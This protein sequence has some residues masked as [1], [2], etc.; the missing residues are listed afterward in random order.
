MHRTTRRKAIAM[1]GAVAGAASLPFPSLAQ[2]RDHVV[3]V[4]GGFGGATCAV[5]LRR[6]APGVDV[7]LIEENAAFATCPFSNAVIAGLNSMD[8]ITHGFDGLKARGVRVIQARAEHVDVE[9]SQVRLTGGEYVDF[10]RLVLSPGVEMKWQAI[11]G[12][13]RSAAEIMP[14]AWK[15]GPQT[16]LLRR[17]LQAMDDGGTVLMGI[18]DSPYRC[19]PGPYERA[20]LIAHYLKTHKPRSKLLL[21]DAKNSFSKQTLF[22]EAWAELYPDLIEWVPFSQIG[23]IRRVDPSD[24]TVHTDF[25]SER[26]DVVNF[27]PPQRAGAIIHAA[28]LSEG[29]DWCRVD[30]RTMESVVAPGV[31][32]LGDAGIMGAMPKSGF[33]AASQAKYCAYVIAAALDEADLPEASFFNTCYSLVAPDYGISVAAVFRIDSAGQIV[34]IEGS[35]GASPEGASADFRQREADYARGWYASQTKEIYDMPS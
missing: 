23:A 25:A 30:P 11:E 12:Y 26:G 22:Q 32:V 27:I 24:M 18:P 1:T 7:T 17:Q 13:D 31:H 9:N 21:L 34:T 2:R 35:G 8:D 6:L 14:H 4:G 16:E 20:S 10:D 15:A 33:S 3:V 28:G 29:E 5:H 19:P